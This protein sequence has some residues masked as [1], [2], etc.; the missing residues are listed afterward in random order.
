MTVV[1]SCSGGGCQRL[2]DQ[3]CGGNE[4][5]GGGRGRTWGCHGGEMSGYENDGIVGDCRRL[6]VIC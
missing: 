2:H 1:R 5:D 6:C 4:G 3:D